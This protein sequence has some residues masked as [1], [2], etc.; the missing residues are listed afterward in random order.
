[1][2][3]P[4]DE[5][6]YELALANRI[7]AH[8]GV[9]AALAS[10]ASGQRGDSMVRAHSASK[11]RVNALVTLALKR[12]RRR[13]TPSAMSACATPPIP[14]AICLP[15]PQPGAGRAVGHLR[16]HARL[17]AGVVGVRE[18]LRRARHPRLHLSGAARGQRGP[19]AATKRR[20]AKSIAS[21]NHASG[22][23]AHGRDKRR[24]VTLKYRR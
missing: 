15:L 16:I 4:L 19:R 13:A 8:E 11:T 10:E 14:A 5:A 18:L 21:D 7:I 6:R 3:N 23:F 9:Q 12:A 1:M 17:R 22:E 24:P 2:P 20:A